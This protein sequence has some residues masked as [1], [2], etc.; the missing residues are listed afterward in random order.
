MPS[1]PLTNRAMIDKYPTVARQGTTL[2][3]F[4]STY[5]EADQRWQLNVRTRA[6][7]QW[8]PVTPFSALAPFANNNIQRR[9]PW[10]VTES[11]GML[12]LFWLELVGQQWQ[13]RYNRYDGTNWAFP[14]AP[15]TFPLDAGADPRV[16]GPPFVVFHRA[17]R[18]NPCG[19]S[20]REPNQTVP[21][22]SGAGVS[23]TGSRQV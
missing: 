12:W 21:Q 2:R 5:N 19:C 1:E 17:I 22:G 9:Q 18:H 4:W 16:E 20:G 14:V 13:L 8:S 7:N 6:N 3:V 10:A 15:A 23:C 11:T